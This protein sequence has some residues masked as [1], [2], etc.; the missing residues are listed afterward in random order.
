MQH[1]FATSTSTGRRVF[2]RVDFNVPLKNGAISDDTRIRASLPTI[3]YAL[4][5]GAT[6]DPRAR[7]SAGPK[8]KPNPEFSLRPVADAPGRAARP[9]GR[10][11]GRLHRRRPRATADRARQRGRRRPAREPALPPRGGEERPGVR[12]AARGARRRLRER[13][14]RRRRTARTRRSKASSHYVPGV[15][16]RAADGGGA[17]VPGHGARAPGAAVRRDPRRREGVGQD[18]GHREPARQGR[19][20]AHRRRDGLHVLQGARACRSASRSSRTTSSTTARDDRGAREGARHAR[21]SCRSIT[22]SPPK[23]EAGAPAETLA[24]GDAAIGD[25]MGLDIGPTTVA[26]YRDG[27][28]AARRPSSGTARWACSRSTRSRRAR[29]PSRRRSPA[30]TGTTIIGGGD[31]IA[32]VEEGRRRRPDHAHLDRRR[33]VA[34]VP[35]RPDAARASRR[36]QQST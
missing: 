15:G 17:R 30:C 20:A 11:R 35:R 26:R 2:I 29:S 18:R 25:R 19:R 16:R 24:V 31:S 6:V 21:S 10:V 3:Q 14:V 9:P 12:R 1:R 33:R 5:Q 8:G 7:I 4:E 36:S 32:A 23:L 28:R 22:S 34:R 27:H 13:R